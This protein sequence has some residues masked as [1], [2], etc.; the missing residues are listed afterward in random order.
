VTGAPVF[1]LSALGFSLGDRVEVRV[2]RRWRPG[3][4]TALG[5]RRVTVEY[6]TRKGL[7]RHAAEFGAQDVRRP[8]RPARGPK[9]GDR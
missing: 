3:W 4:V 9:A 1:G 7:V 8:S 6:W 5:R 2:F